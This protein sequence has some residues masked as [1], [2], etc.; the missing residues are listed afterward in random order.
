VIEQDHRRITANLA[1]AR[2]KRF[3]TAAVTIQGI[4]WAEKIKKQQFDLKLLTGKASKAP[5]IWGRCPVC[6]ES[7]KSS[8]Q[9][10][11]YT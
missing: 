8:R 6:L 4:E 7:A 10:K 1:D 2:F 3:E 11:T 5:D 9:T